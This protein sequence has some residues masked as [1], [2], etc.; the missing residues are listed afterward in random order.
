METCSFSKYAGFTGVRL[1]WT[2]VPE[3]LKFADGSPVIN[4]FNR[5]MTTI[6][7][8][9]S[10]IAQAGGLAAL[11]VRLLLHMCSDSV[12]HPELKIAEQLSFFLMYT[13]MCDANLMPNVLNG[14]PAVWEALQRRQD[15]MHRMVPWADSVLGSAQE[16]QIC[17]FWGVR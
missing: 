13:A 3:Q 6:F 1:G 14:R 12:L 4:D 17:L 15:I 2:V 5:I 16:H 10:V 7:N 11:E 8:G 9:A